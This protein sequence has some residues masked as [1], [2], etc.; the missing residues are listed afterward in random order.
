MSKQLFFFLFLSCWCLLFVLFLVTVISLPIIVCS[1]ISIL[2]PANRP[3]GPVG[4]V[5]ANVPG[6]LGSIPGRVIPKTFKT[7]HN[8]HHHVAPS[9]RISPTLSLSLS[10]AISPYRPLLPEGLQGYIP[11]RY[12][13]AV[14]RFELVVQPLLVHVKG[15][16]GVDNLWVRPYFSSSVLHVRFV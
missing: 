4:R 9:V 11:Y 13:A 10:L 15:S 7:H 2:H 1:V 8:H 5:F 3:I 14:C 16:T 6:D 12:W